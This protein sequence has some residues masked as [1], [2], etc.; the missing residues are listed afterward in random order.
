MFP[1]Q[2][3]CGR[4]VNDGGPIHQRGFG[5]R[6]APD[7]LHGTM[8][9]PRNNHIFHVV[10][11]SCKSLLVSERNESGDGAMC[12]NNYNNMKDLSIF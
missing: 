3:F 10:E 5:A 7:W 6:L 1:T 2:M 8:W 12:K 9:G 4:F 11:D